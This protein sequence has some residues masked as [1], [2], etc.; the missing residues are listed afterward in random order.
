[1]TDAT[2]PT[3]RYWRFRGLVRAEGEV[4]AT[5]LDQSYW[6]EVVVMTPAELAAIKA[7]VWTAA[8]DHIAAFIPNDLRRAAHADNPYT[9]SEE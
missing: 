7:E 9:E 8:I 4:A 1:M 2:E 3:V 5:R 6:H